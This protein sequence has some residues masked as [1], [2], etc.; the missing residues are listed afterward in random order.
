MHASGVHIT[1]TGSEA[2]IPAEPPALAARGME[3]AVPD[4]PATLAGAMLWPD[5]AV[6]DMPAAPPAL[7]GMPAALATGR[8]PA[9]PPVPETAPFLVRQTFPTQSMPGQSAS[10]LQRMT[11]SAAGGSH[12]THT[13]SPPTPSSQESPSRTDRLALSM[14]F[15]TSTPLARR[16]S[17]NPGCVCATRTLTQPAPRHR[18]HNWRRAAD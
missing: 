3:A 1:T 8:V 7:G 17:V 11:R 6:A 18:R 10:T 13:S 14:D 16:S 12:A 15:R 2:D 5:T 4:A 9:A